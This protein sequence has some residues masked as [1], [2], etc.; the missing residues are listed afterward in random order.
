MPNAQRRTGARQFCSDGHCTTAIAVKGSAWLERDAP[1]WFQAETAS[2]A[3]T[4]PHH[5]HLAPRISV[6]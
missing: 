2:K 1:K 4:L 5:I 6:T 3:A